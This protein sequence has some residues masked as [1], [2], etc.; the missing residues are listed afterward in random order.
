M[1]K[2][3][4]MQ[5]GFTFGPYDSSDWEDYEFEL[6]DEEAALFNEAVSNHKNP[7][8]ADE[9]EDLRDRARA[10]IE[11]MI[12]D[13]MACDLEGCIINMKIVYPQYGQELTEEDFRAI[14]T[15]MYKEAGETTD[16]IVEFIQDN[17][18]NEDV[19]MDE[20]ADEVRQELGIEQ[21]EEE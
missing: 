7:N 19:D 10:E 2:Y 12:A 21:D 20:L 16:E 13:D 6:T 18:D 3:I 4:D 14:L 5:Y 11:E 17:I 8:T 15:E 1:G 9:L